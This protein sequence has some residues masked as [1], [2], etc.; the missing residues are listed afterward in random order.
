VQ[1]YTSD[2]DSEG[3]PG[4]RGIRTAA[5]VN[6]ERHHLRQPAL[7]AFHPLC[8][9]L[10][11]TFLWTHGR[12]LYHGEA[13]AL[14]TLIGCHLYGW[15]FDKTKGDLTACGVRFRPR[16]IGCTWDEVRATFARIPEHA[17]HLGWPKNFFH[18]RSISDET[19]REMARR[20]DAD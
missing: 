17:D 11:N 3:R 9:I 6:R 8:H 1:T 13:V 15:R 19:F 2:I 5:E 14:G 18:H 7:K 16:E 12:D 4:Q 10:D 20:I